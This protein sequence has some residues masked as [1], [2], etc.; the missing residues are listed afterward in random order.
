[1]TSAE[2]VLLQQQS[3]EEL[4]AQLQDPGVAVVLTLSPQVGARVRGASAG[5]SAWRKEATTPAMVAGLQCKLSRAGQAVGGLLA[6]CERSVPPVLQELPPWVGPCAAWAPEGSCKRSVPSPPPPPLPA[7]PLQSITSLAAFYGLA[8]RD[9]AGRLAAA[10]RSLGAAAVFDLS[11]SRDVALLEAAAEF[12]SRYRGSPRG[13]AE[14]ASCCAGGNA[15]AVGG[16][17]AAVNGGGGG[18]AGGGGG[19]APLPMLA[20]ACPGWVCYAEKTHGTFVLPY[21]SSTRSP[22]VGWACAFVCW[23]CAGAWGDR[24]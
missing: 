16:A 10:L 14:L 15:A 2:T 9:A 20:S 21:I 12:V 19:P 3:T 17:A 18:E 23:L 13:A 22:Q 7:L 4:E 5:R 1:M 8:P 11:A 24:C 6:S